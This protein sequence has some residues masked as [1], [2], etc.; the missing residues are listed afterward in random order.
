MLVQ[1]FPQAFQ[2]KH[3]LKG[4]SLETLV[5]KFANSSNWLDRF[6]GKSAPIYGRRT[7]Q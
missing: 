3:L 4:F 2:E 7:A 1:N 6:A 5:C